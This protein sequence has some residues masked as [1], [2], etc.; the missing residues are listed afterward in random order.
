M[1][2]RGGEHW[3]SPRSGSAQQGPDL[4]S[5]TFGM[6]FLDA[7]RIFS[8]HRRV[9]HS[10]ACPVIELR[11]SDVELATR[12]RVGVA[13]VVDAV[14]GNAFRHDAFRHVAARR[15][16]GSSCAESLCPRVSFVGSADRRDALSHAAV[17]GIRLEGVFCNNPQAPGNFA[18][19]RSESE[20]REHVPKSLAPGGACHES[21]SWRTA[22]RHDAAHDDSRQQNRAHVPGLRVRPMSAGVTHFVGDRA[23]RAARGIT[24]P[25]NQ[26]R[27]AVCTS[28][29]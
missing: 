29:S 16:F 1:R 14:V 15:I 28:R 11:R 21:G 27:S 20:A 5:S 26:T 25:Q 24:T 3:L 8:R 13:A 6:D 12:A 17:P 22:A 4:S 7:L 2:N 18:Q 10:L 19:F 23:R 9:R